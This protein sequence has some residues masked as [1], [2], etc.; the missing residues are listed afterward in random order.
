MA[1]QL[2]QLHRFRITGTAGVLL[3]AKQKGLIPVVAPYLQNLKEAGFLER[4]NECGPLLEF[5]LSGGRCR[6]S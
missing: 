4:Q 2:A 3:R 6:W 5:R 1:R